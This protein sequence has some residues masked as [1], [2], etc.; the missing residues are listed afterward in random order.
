M[1]IFLRYTDVIGVIWNSFDAWNKMQGCLCSEIFFAT[2]S[3][4]RH[5]NIKATELCKDTKKAFGKID[6]GPF[7]TEV[8]SIHFFIL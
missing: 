2:Y 4:L 6:V 7:Q 1:K 8:N 5:V 3:N